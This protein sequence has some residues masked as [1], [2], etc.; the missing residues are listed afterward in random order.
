MAQAA[1]DNNRVSAMIGVLNTDGE[2]IAE[3]KATPSTHILDVAIGVGGS[4]FGDNNAQKDPNRISTLLAAS[5]AD[6]GAVVPL[7][8]DS[9]G[10][11]LIKST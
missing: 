8:V 3:V 6:D 1:K 7:Y 11:L 4:D 10:C 5:S 9:S 2:T